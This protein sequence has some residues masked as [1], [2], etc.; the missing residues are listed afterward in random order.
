MPK[1]MIIIDSIV[2]GVGVVVSTIISNGYVFCL[3]LF[4]ISIFHIILGGLNTTKYIDSKFM[5][6]IFND[7]E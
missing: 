4:V 6:W 5:R 1:G 2:C 7:K 3:F